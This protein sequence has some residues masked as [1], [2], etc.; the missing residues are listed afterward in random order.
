MTNKN[1][2]N[3]II[4][5]NLD[6]NL[7]LDIKNIYLHDIIFTKIDAPTNILRYNRNKKY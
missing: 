4:K 7:I 3:I 2:N 5:F 1:Y 6:I